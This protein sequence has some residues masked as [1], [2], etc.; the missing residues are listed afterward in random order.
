M[1]AERIPSRTQAE[2]V[3]YFDGG[4][5]GTSRAL[6]T[7]YEACRNAGWIEPTDSF[8]FH[9]TTDAGRRALTAFENRVPGKVG[10]PRK[11]NRKVTVVTEVDG[12]TF[13]AIEAARG[14]VTRPEW[15]RQAI[16]N[17]LAAAT[18]G[19]VA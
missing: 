18:D 3:R 6:S 11:H 13:D 17:A 16:R 10:R 2:L 19:K 9:R 15:L 8:P 14:G 12:P 5:V 1:L 7:T 4:P